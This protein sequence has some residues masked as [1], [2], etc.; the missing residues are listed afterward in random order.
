MLLHKYAPTNLDQFK[1]SDEVRNFYRMLIQS[2][3]LHIMLVG[4]RKTSL[5]HAMLREYY[6]DVNL[7]IQTSNNVMYIN[8][9]IEHGVAF[10]RQSLKTFCQSHFAVKGKFKKTVVLDNL[11]CVKNSYIQQICCNLIET[12]SEHVNFIVSC[13]NIKQIM[14]SIQSHCLSLSIPS[15]TSEQTSCILRDISAKENIEL[16]SQVMEYIISVS[17]NN[18]NVM[19]NYLEKFKL[20]G[21]PITLELAKIM[22]TNISFDIFNQYMDAVMHHRISDAM[23]VMSHL[24]DLGYSVI[25]VLETFFQFV[26]SPHCQ[27]GDDIKYII[28]PIICEYII[29][30]NTIQENNVDLFFLTNKLI[31]KLTPN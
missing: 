6:C 21:E 16:E 11:D 27:L 4:E 1:L 9:M 14:E 3:T 10:Y 26:K 28:I 19:V 15:L 17:N 13:T 24:I 30:F 23:G 31:Q 20:L 25:D 8:N 22:C 12:Y 18:M 29:Y 2:N 7:N 5:I